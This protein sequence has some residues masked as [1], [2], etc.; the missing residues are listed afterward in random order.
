MECAERASPAANAIC[1]TATTTTRL[2]VASGIVVVLLPPPDVLNRLVFAPSPTTPQRLHPKAPATPKPPPTMPPPTAAASPTHHRSTV[3]A[4]PIGQR[5]AARPLAAPRTHPADTHTRPQGSATANAQAAAGR[6]PRPFGFVGVRGR[7]ALL[8]PCRRSCCRAQGRRPR[9]GGFAPCWLR[10]ASFGLGWFRLRVFGGFVIFLLV[11][12]GDVLAIFAWLSDSCVV[13]CRA[14]GL[15]PGRFL[16]CC[17]PSS[18]LSVSPAP[19]PALLLLLLPCLH[20]PRCLLV[21][22]FSWVAPPA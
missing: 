15:F 3:A 16:P 2:D 20:C 22:P 6:G 4:A 9:C 7:A 21:V 1:A 14:F 19:V 11:S 5:T 13:F 17:Y 8:S 18:L 12:F 10:S